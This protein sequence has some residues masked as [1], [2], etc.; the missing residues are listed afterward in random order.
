[1][2]WLARSNGGSAVYGCGS[3]S[4]SRYLLPSALG[5]VFALH[6]WA[7]WAPVTRATAFSALAL[8]R[9]FRRERRGCSA[10]RR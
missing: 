7:G 10:K 1:M 6:L 5:A 4:R 8:L 3:G 2:Q 9:G